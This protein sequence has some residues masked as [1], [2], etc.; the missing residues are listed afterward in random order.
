MKELRNERE[1]KLADSIGS[2][3]FVASI[4]VT[5][6]LEDPVKKCEQVKAARGYLERITEHQMVVYGGL[7]CNSSKLNTDLLEGLDF[8]IKINCYQPERLEVIAGEM[9]Q[10]EYLTKNQKAFLG[11]MLESQCDEIPLPSFF[12]FSEM[13]R[14]AYHM[15]V[16]TEVYGSHLS[17]LKGLGMELYV[18]SVLEEEIPDS[19]VIHRH[20]FNYFDRLKNMVRHSEADAIVMCKEDDFYYALYNLC[21]KKEFSTWI[22]GKQ[23]L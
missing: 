6:G 15:G 2:Y 21:K 7:A 16:S 23:L 18:R 5:N 14:C 8:I 9:L 11:Q 13:G 17:N 19:I 22:D 20:E 10:S 4:E 3:G 1:R 12:A